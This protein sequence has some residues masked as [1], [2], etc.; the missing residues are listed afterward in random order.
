MLHLQ[1]LVRIFGLLFLISIILVACEE[2]ATKRQREEY[3]VMRKKVVEDYDDLLLVGQS[4]SLGSFSRVLRKRIDNIRDLKF[5][6]FRRKTK[7]VDSDFDMML[8]NIDDYFI[9]LE[10]A[11]SFEP[12]SIQEKNYYSFKD[13]L[14]TNQEILDLLSKLPVRQG[15]SI[16]HQLKQFIVKVDSSNLEDYLKGSFMSSKDF[17]KDFGNYE[18]LWNTIKISVKGR[19]IS[20]GIL[21]PDRNK[22]HYN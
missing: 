14:S 7:L 11:R 16:T 10:E 8:A 9:V 21:N 17:E 22:R 4:R 5:Y 18:V 2:E 19:A 6:E 20:E 13:S 3:N 12:S 1:S 15:S